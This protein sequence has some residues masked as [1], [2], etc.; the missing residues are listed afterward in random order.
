MC[1]ALGIKLVRE[2][3][4]RIPDLREN[5]VGVSRHL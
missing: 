5:T 3:K 2:K 4:D 1:Q